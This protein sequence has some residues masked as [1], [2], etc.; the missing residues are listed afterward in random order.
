VSKARDSPL[1][2]ARIHRGEDKAPQPAV[3]QH[4]P[5]KPAAGAGVGP[6]PPNHP[7]EPDPIAGRSI[8]SHE[9]SRVVDCSG[10]ANL[11]NPGAKQG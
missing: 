3:S 11:Y 7:A 1:E 8:L 2:N 9:V 6:G 10:K 4:P 5:P